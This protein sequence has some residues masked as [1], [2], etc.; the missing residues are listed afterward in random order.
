MF[1]NS[2]Y[3]IRERVG[4]LKLAD[5]YDIV[6][7]DTGAQV[8]VAHEKPHWAV[9][10]LRFLIDKRL[11][12][13]TVFIAPT[14]DAAPVL[15]IHRGPAFFRSKVS[16]KSGDGKEIGYFRSKFLSLGG[17]FRVFDRHDNQIAEIKGDWK[18]WNFKFLG[19][20]GTEIG[21]VTKKWAGLAKEFFTSADNYVI[22]LAQ[23]HSQEAM[24]I[25]MAAGIAIDTVYKEGR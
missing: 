12:P 7:A 23:G 8:G 18:G 9:H 25:L 20:D 22:N 24:L 6:E 11:L 1:T 14:M 2:T 4:L 16:V 15:S 13:T 3:L 5:T 17:A 10:V 19:S 21:T